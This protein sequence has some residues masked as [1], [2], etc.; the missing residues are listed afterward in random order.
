[1]NREWKLNL[2]LTF[3]IFILTYIYNN[4]LIISSIN[5]IYRIL[6]VIKLIII[7][8]KTINLIQPKKKKRSS[9]F[10]TKFFP[11][12]LKQATSN[13]LDYDYINYHIIIIIES[14]MR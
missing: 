1:M 2:S 11:E 5:I 7:K 8:T 9:W 4:S 12:K 14:N 13:I 6:N 3:I 10:F